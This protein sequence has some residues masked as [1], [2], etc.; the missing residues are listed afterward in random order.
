MKAGDTKT[1]EE[2]GMPSMV[3]MERAALQCVT[4]MEQNAIDLSRPLIVCG[5]GNNGGDGFAIARLLHLKGCSVKTVMV[6]NESSCSIETTQQIQILKKYG[7][8][9]DNRI[10]PGEYSVI[11]DAIFGIGLSREINGHY[12]DILQTLNEMNGTKIAVDIPSGI[13]ATTGAVLGIAFRADMTVSFACEKLGT[14]LYPGHLYAGK[15]VPVDIG[16]DSSVFQGEHKI[17]FTYTRKDAAL[18]VPARKPNSHK[19]TYGK[20][21]IIA[22]SRGMAGAAYLCAKAAYR[23]GSGLVQIYTPESNRIVLQQLLPEAIIT[24]YDSWKREEVLS[25]IEQADVIAVG[26]GLGTS[27]VAVELVKTILENASKPCIL[28]ADA[29]NI[30]ADHLSCIHD[31]HHQ[32]LLTPHMKEMT[33]LLSCSIPDLQQNRFSYLETFTEKY[34]L[35]C[36]L[37]DARTVITSPDTGFYVNTTGNS[38]LAKGGSGDVLTGIIAGLAAQG[39]TLYHAATLGVY[40]HGRMGD[41]A[42]DKSDVHT[43]LASDMIEELKNVFKELKEEAA[44]E[45]L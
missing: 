23:T 25:L 36:V 12:K 41:Y 26:P 1:I 18:L 6:G 40:M 11:I 37:K 44:N 45:K 39:L 21:L 7:V 10:C 14:V 2:F 8:S 34:N 4:V 22:G 9:I 20:T 33:R 5:S 3:L 27:S 28:D 43:V 42:R 16:I 24:T 32:L 17:A 31:K 38:A 19:G 30:L 15:V 35:T 29:I 13:S